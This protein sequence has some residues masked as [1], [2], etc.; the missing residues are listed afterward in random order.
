MMGAIEAAE[1]IGCRIVL[2]D[3]DINITLQRVLNKMTFMEKAKFVF[4]CISAFITGD[5]EEINIEDLKKE[6][7][8]EEMME[9]YAFDDR[10]NNIITENEQMVGQHI[11]F[12]E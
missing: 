11:D 3:R 1:E 4:S 12:R 2:I 9:E 8:I 7:V 5:D 6:D 10:S